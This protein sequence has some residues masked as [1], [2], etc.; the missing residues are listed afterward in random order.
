[1]KYVQYKLRGGELRGCDISKRGGVAPGRF[2]EERA[3]RGLV[4]EAEHTWE[5][6]TN[7]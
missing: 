5:L 3:E 7:N 2:R 1:M 4:W 6:T